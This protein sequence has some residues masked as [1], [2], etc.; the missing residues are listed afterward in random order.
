MCF[1]KCDNVRRYVEEAAAM[2]R[3]RMD[4]SEG[5]Q[6]VY[7]PAKKKKKGGKPAALFR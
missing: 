6:A 7:Q 1:S 5:V 3:A 4:G 2:K